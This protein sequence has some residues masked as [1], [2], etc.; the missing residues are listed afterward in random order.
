[1][2]G[3]SK[4]CFIL[5]SGRSLLNLTSEE[6]EYVNG[7]PHT[8]AM[9]KFYLFYEKVGIE[10]TALFMA[11]TRFPTHRVVTEI[12]D[13]ARQS[14]KQPTYYLENYYVNLFCKPYIHP[15]W[16]TRERLRLL[17]MNRYI[18]PLWVN[19]PRVRS[20]RHLQGVYDGFGWAKSLDEPLYWLHG[21]LTT[22]INLAF[23]IYPGC[24][25]KLIGVDLQG[26]EPF[27]DEELRVRPDLMDAGYLRNKRVG[28]H[29]TAIASKNG[30]TM[31]QSIV[32]LIK[33]ALAKERIRLLCCTSDSLL[34]SENICEYA[35]IVS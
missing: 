14:A 34:V 30:V 28:Q 1:M 8:L 29:H 18:A 9:N 35:N 12:I 7:H 15:L 3:R 25:I 31:L 33:P 27:F 26:P 5:G 13:K 10:P 4:D 19:Y 22:A 11:D 2:E 21:S 24:D 20:F 6:R 17:R 16:N 32:D 23:I